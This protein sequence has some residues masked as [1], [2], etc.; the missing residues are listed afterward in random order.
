MGIKGSERVLISCSVR[1]TVF[2]QLA[3]LIIDWRKGAKLQSALYG[4]TTRARIGWDA[5]IAVTRNGY[6][7]EFCLTLASSC[8]CGFVKRVI[9]VVR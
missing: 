6:I 7:Q 5:C 3:C 8:R 1:P 9:G 4:E 2:K